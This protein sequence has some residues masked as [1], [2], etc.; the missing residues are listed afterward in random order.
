M[1]KRLQ[2]L[3]S[4]PTGYRRGGVKLNNGVNQIAADKFTQ[5]QMQQLKADPKLSVSEIE[6]KA[7]SSADSSG[8]VDGDT[9]SSRV[10][11][12]SKATAAE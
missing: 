11:R 3:C 10:T 6:D 12:K 2:I 9:S 5:T 7:D 1:A 4:A 8:N